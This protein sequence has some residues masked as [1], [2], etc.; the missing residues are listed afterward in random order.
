MKE[1]ANSKLEKPCFLISSTTL[2]V[3]ASWPYVQT[4]NS[5]L[6]HKKVW[7]LSVAT[8]L[9]SLLST[10]RRSL[11]CCEKSNGDYACACWVNEKK[12]LLFWLIVSVYIL[13]FCLWFKWSPVGLFLASKGKQFDIRFE[14]LFPT[15]RLFYTIFKLPF[16]NYLVFSVLCFC[17]RCNTSS[18]KYL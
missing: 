7:N 18:E 4:L 3:S 8:W 15:S 1:T 5:Q 10:H 2:I 9:Q 17:L 14:V 13:G 12:V 11:E 6:P 16:G